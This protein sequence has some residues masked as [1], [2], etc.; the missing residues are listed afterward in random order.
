M[1]YELTLQPIRINSAVGIA[2]H[3]RVGVKSRLKTQWIALHIPSRTW[4]VISEPIVEETCLFVKPLA[5]EAQVEF[6]ISTVSIHV[7]VG[8]DIAKRFTVV[9]RPHNLIEFVSNVTWGAKGIRLTL[10]MQAV[11]IKKRALSAHFYNY[12]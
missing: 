6:K 3:I 10:Y 1:G 12:I 4:V 2:S 7:F 5:R 8:C 11:I 9:P